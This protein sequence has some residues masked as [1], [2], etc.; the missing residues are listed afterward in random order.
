[1]TFWNRLL[2]QKDNDNKGNLTDLNE[3]GV[4]ITNELE[5]I[6]FHVEK[7]MKARSADTQF[8]HLYSEFLKE[9][10]ND[11]EKAKIYRSEINKIEIPDIYN[12]NDVNLD[13]NRM[14]DICQ[15]IIASSE[16][17]NFLSISEI[18]SGLC[19]MLGYMKSELLGQ[20]LNIVLPEIYKNDHD[21]NLKSK[22]EDHR[23]NLSENIEDPNKTKSKNDNIEI[24]IFAKTKARYIIPL[25]H[26]INLAPSNEHDKLYFIARFRSDNDNYLAKE[27]FIITNKSFII[28]QF[29]V[30]LFSIL[31]IDKEIITIGITELAKIISEYTSNYSFESELD[32]KGNFSEEFLQKYSTPVEFEW[33]IF[34]EDCKY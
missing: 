15:Y 20:N 9:I 29:T 32:S 17:E 25:Y 31:E 1:M 23:Q 3:I 34:N 24:K 12:D 19:A 28:Q 8:L 13:F 27:V 4:M 22:I 33:R 11:K 16:P 6:N 10:T 21:K 14:N 2:S 26:K 30:N 7:M 5:D 18:S